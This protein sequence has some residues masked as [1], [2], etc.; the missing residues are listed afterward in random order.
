[1]LE[2]CSFSSAV[3]WDVMKENSPPVSFVALSSRGRGRTHN[4]R[5]H[6]PPQRANPVVDEMSIHAATRHR[7]ALPKSGAGIRAS[8]RSV[9]PRRAS[10]RPSVSMVTP[11]RTSLP[12]GSRLMLLPCT[13]YRVSTSAL[14]PACPLQPD[15]ARG[16][17]PRL[18]RSNR[19]HSRQRLRPL[20][21][22]RSWPEAR[23]HGDE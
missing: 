9:M 1:M 5:D 2:Q 23:P 18:S 6:H 4:E 17:S 3:P 22:G 13:R 14:W 12:A 16:R 21:C 15:G 20:T 8:A 10:A 11:W 19:M 7:S